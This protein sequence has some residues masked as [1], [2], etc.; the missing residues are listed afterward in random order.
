MTRNTRRIATAAA[1]LAAMCAMA[2]P[3]GAADATLKRL[4]GYKAPGTPSK[5]NRVGVLKFGSSKARNVL[6]LNPGTSA[7]AAY[8]APLARDIVRKAKGWQVWA[9]ERRENLLEDHSVADRVKAGKADGKELF[10]YYLGFTTDS[11]IQKHFRLIPDS[12]VGYARQWG[13]RVEVEDLRR[14]VLSAKRLGGRVVVGGHSLGGSI[15]TAYATWDFGGKPGA[16]GLSGLVFIDG[17]SGPNPVTVDQANQS[18]DDLEKGSPWLAFGGISAPFAGLFNVVS[19]GLVKVEPD[20][21]SRLADFAGLPANL[22]PPVE[23][24]SVGGYGYALDN[25]TSPS[26]LAAAQAHLGHLAAS[27]DPRGWDRAGELTPIQRYADMFF[28]TGLKGLDGTAW[29]HPRRLTIDSGAVAAGNPNPA[30][31]VLN[32]RATHGDDL[33]KSLRLYAFGAALG[34]QRVIDATRSLAKQSGIPKSRVTLVNR[35]STYS[36]NDPNSASPK[37]D[38]V[39]YL[40]PYLKKVQGR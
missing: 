4:D 21:R 33:P 40:L 26:S 12:E 2:A 31:K 32:V 6:V 34:G 7:S 38:F 17:G 35:A 30:Q 39:R 29:Y 18:I 25:E 20:V 16:K 23:T 19:A 24:T 27:G 8:F 5:Y 37:N 3:A 9:V 14:V 15:T 1:A 13:M 11:S 36:H 28:G 10:E 22:R